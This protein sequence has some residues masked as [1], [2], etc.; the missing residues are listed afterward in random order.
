MSLIWWLLIGA[1]AGWLSGQIMKGRGFGVLGN[2]LVGIIGAIL[3][4]WL[5]GILGISTG[6]SIVGS[7]ITALVGAM[8]LLAIVGAVKKAA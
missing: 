2:I 7:L 4:G 3:G 6:T 1:A 5:F 8:V